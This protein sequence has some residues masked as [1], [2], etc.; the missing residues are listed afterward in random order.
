MRRLSG[1]VWQ[2]PMLAL[3]ALCAAT[4]TA[5]FAADSPTAPA[6]SPKTMTD[7]LAA[8]KPSDWRALD[9]ENTLYMEL[10]RGR[11]VIEL[12]PRFAPNHV[13]T[14][15]AL[16]REHYYDGL[17]IERVQDDY[18]AQWG[19]P[20]DRRS[21]GTVP[22][23]LA[24]EFSR[25]SDGLEFVRLPDPDTYAPETGFVD[26]FP[27][28]RDPP[29]HLAWLTHCYAMVGAGRDND[30]NSGGGRELYVVIGHAPR[31]LDRNVTLLG[32]VVQGIEQLSSLPRGSGPLGFYKNPSER[33]PIRSI[34]IAAD[35]PESQRSRLEVLRTDTQTF[36]ELIE[37]RRNRR[38]EWFKVKADRIDVCNIPLPVRSATQPD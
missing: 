11:V 12:A 21:T 23:S 16:A 4:A 32:R 30:A 26:G 19:D 20:D 24:A 27:A 5:A 7:V 29:S 36:T 35:L 2:S 14:I 10:A 15:R 31:N 17:V 25:S 28:A 13:A 37:S 38:E 8:S 22:R 34:R 9:P 18:V 3:L 6:G 33:I 1:T